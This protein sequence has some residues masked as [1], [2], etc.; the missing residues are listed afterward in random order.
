MKQVEK[1]AVVLIGLTL[2]SRIASLIFDRY[3]LSAPDVEASASYHTAIG[4][5]R[6]LM[7]LVINMAIGVWVYRE[8]AKDGRTPW[9]WA[10]LALLYGMVALIAFM[11]LPLYDQRRVQSERPMT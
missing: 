11:V 3:L 10:L 1:A 5:L 6:V 4:S 8:A 2:A 9:V 7:P